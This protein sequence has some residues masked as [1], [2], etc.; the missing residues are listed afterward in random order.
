LKTERTDLLRYAIETFR[1]NIMRL[2]S[3]KKSKKLDLLELSDM[4]RIKLIKT[5]RESLQQKVVEAKLWQSFTD[6]NN[7][8][9]NGKMVHCETL[10][11]KGMSI[12]D[13]LKG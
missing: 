11:M 5:I 1:G 9:I 6:A 7:L 12:T 3:E 2:R 4:E 8:T 10:P 13:L